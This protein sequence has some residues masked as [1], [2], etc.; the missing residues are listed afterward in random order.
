LKKHGLD[1]ETLCEQPWVDSRNRRSPRREGT[2]VESTRFRLVPQSLA[3]LRS[4]VLQLGR[5]SRQLYPLPIMWSVVRHYGILAALRRAIEGG[6]YRVVV[7]LTG[8]VLWL[9]SLAIFEK[10]Y[11]KSTAGSTDEPTEIAP[12]CSPRKRRLEHI[13]E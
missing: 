7:S 3:S 10:A 1:A 9:L 11:A 2:V 13:R 5:S 6:S 12:I 4:K 8:T